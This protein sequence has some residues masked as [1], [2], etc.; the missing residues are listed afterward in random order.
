MKVQRNHR[1]RRSSAA[2]P[3]VQRRRRRRRPM[4][5][6]NKLR[7]WTILL[8]ILALAA[9]GGL[10]FYF[11]HS[12]IQPFKEAEE[13]NLESQNSSY[14]EN[15]SDFP[16]YD[17]AFNLVLANNSHPLPESYEPRITTLDGVETEERIVVYLEALLRAAQA[18][19]VDLKLSSGYVSR[20]KQDA[21]Y[22]AELER[23]EQNGMPRAKAE[24][25][26]RRTVGAGGNNDFQ[27]GLAVRFQTEG[28]GDFSRTKAYRWL[29]SN[30]IRY[31]FVLRCPENKTDLTQRPYDPSHFRFVGVKHA[32]RMQ[33]LSLCLEEYA[34][35]VKMQGELEK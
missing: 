1:T 2:V 34:D 35:Y 20:E 30:S 13:R 25:T 32:T 17:D 27:T 6:I 23:L 24:N 33:E 15:H 4:E 8:A 19:G 7:L 28:S 11:W 14:F 16:V 10:G 21:L 5:Q 3:K 22:Q 12:F 31:G 26:A 18:E 9:A 29:L